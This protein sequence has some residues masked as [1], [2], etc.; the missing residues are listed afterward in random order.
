[1]NIRDTV[2]Y[3]ELGY[4]IVSCLV[5]GNETLDFYWICEH[6]D[7]EYDG[8]TDENDFSDANGMTVKE[9][10]QKYFNKQS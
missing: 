10:R 6:C 2:K 9:Y 7:W 4:E 3:K 1:M 8:T 5:C